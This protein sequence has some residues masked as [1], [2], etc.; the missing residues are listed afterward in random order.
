MRKIICALSLLM[1][2][3]AAGETVAG[4]TFIAD[5]PV[6]TKRDKIKIEPTPGVNNC[7]NAGYT[8]TYCDADEEGVGICPYDSGYFRYCCPAGYRYTRK[9]CLQ[10]GMIPS[11]KT[12]HSYHACEEPEYDDEY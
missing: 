6:H 8:K 10:M 11:K 5:S 2:L 7:M 4:V 12:C 3:F 9:E 1:F